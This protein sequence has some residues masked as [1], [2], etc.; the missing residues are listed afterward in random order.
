MKNLIYLMLI[1]TVIFSCSDDDDT[2]KITCDQTTVIDNNLYDAAQSQDLTI[3]S[4]VLS[5][6]CL[7]AYY[8]ASGCDGE[9]WA[10]TLLDSGN[11]AESSPEQRFLTFDFINEEECRAVISKQ[12]SFDLRPIQIDSDEI[13]LNFSID[14]Y[15]QSINYSY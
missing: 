9:T 12:T 3:D 13:I 14:G 15:E 10:I 4:L 7:H 2:S 5:G 8:K 1:V 11:I 6:D